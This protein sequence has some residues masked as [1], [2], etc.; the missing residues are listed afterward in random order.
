[1][2]TYFTNDAV[3][4]LRQLQRNNDRGWF[5]ANQD[6]YE[7]LVRE[8][9]REFIRD[10]G[11]RLQ[12]RISSHLTASDKKVGGSLMRPQRDTRFGKDKTPYKTNIGIQFRH[13]QGK[14]VHAP[15]LYVHIDPKEVFLGAGMWRPDSDAL[16]RIR[17]RITSKPTSWKKVRDEAGFRRHFELGGDALK[18][19]PR[20]FDPEHPFVDDLRRTDHIAVCSLTAKQAVGPAFARLVEDRF[21]AARRYMKFLA[22]AIDL[23]F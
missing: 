15:G 7:S 6:R 4:F 2:P 21:I 5:K 14:D 11:P 3:N 20:G 1:M 22:D 16:R 17:E 8:P 9:A 12:K 19:S 13:A 18:R 23:P 10:V